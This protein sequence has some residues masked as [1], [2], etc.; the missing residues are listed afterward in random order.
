MSVSKKQNLFILLAAAVALVFSFLPAVNGLTREGLITVGIFF[1]SL[2]MWITVS[3]DW[4]SFITLIALGFLPSVGFGD[5]FKG[6]F[7]N[8]T[9][10]FLIFTFML[11]YPLSKTNFV[12][13]CTVWFITNR[14]AR[15][16]PWF[17][18]CSLFAAITFMGLFISPSVLFVAFMPF[19][20]DIFCVLEI[21]KGGKTGKMIMMGTAF[22]ISLSSGMTA[23]GHA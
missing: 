22:F 5:T 12:R 14:V 3:I 15:K 13:R 16:G 4:P 19:L 1:A 10:A 9:V 18:V 17:F 8:S 6:A 21:K 2:I 7:S 23:L 20:E 11:V